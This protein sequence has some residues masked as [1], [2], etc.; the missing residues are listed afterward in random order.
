M[1]R[2]PLRS[3][4]AECRCGHPRSAHR[5]LRRGSDCALCPGTCPRFRLRLGS[6][7]GRPADDGDDAPT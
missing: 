7:L 2:S 1:P 6:L 3:D 4:A 5:H